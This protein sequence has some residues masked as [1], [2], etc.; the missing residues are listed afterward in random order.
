MIVRDDA[1][2]NFPTK[3]IN[4]NYGEVP[5]IIG[6]DDSITENGRT[7]VTECGIGYE[8]ID[9]RQTHFVY[10]RDARGRI[11]FPVIRGAESAG[12]R[13]ATRA[14]ALD[15][16]SQLVLHPLTIEALPLARFGS[17]AIVTS[18]PVEKPSTGKWISG[19]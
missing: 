12:Q 11:P 15:R 7:L 10:S 1:A 5:A 9:F 17:R 16:A 4:R 8:V 3:R 18:R 13:P 19:K 14:D 6:L 2:E